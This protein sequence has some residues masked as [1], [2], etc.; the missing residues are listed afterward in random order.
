MS[1]IY[2]MHINVNEINIA[3]CQIWDVNAIGG[4]LNFSS[5]IISLVL[6]IINMELS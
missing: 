3:I 2:P 4:H 5:I 1:K 6:I